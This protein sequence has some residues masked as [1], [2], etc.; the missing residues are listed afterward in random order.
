MKQ[1]FLAF[2]LCLL[3]ILFTN[4]GLCKTVEK[5]VALVD[6]EPVTLYALE[7]GLKDYGP[8]LKK[9]GLVNESSIRAKV[10]EMLIDEIILQKAL[11]NSKLEVKDNEIDSH[12]DRIMRSARINREAFLSE[13]QKKG[14]S[15]E[16]YRQNLRKQLLQNKFVDQFIGSK[17]TITEAEMR[18]Y[19]NKHL[20]EFSNPLVVKLAQISILFTPET[21][22]EDLN[23]V[24]DLAFK[25]VQAANK[26]SDFKT[27]ASKYKHPKFKIEGGEIGVVNV[28]DL[29]P[30]IS[31][32]AR[33]LQ[34]GQVGMPILTASGIIIIKVLDRAK[35]SLKDFSNVRNDVQNVLYQQKIQRTIEAFVKKERKATQIEIKGLGM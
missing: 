1:K 9:S 22:D 26:S 29:Q 31:E 33:Q 16:Q 8:G 35:A 20:D 7:Q 27:I 25:I 2:S 4:T 5:V 34:I 19:F 10:L 11:A 18:E 24:Q 32:V 21:N 15:E 13:L 17:I 14:F 28:K 6:G 30:K 12:I 23:T 3:C